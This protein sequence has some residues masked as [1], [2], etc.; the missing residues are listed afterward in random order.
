MN[1]IMFWNFTIKTN[2]DKKRNSI[3]ETETLCNLGLSLDWKA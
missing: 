2:N 1:R 3:N